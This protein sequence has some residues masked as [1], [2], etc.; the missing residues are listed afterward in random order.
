[1]NRQDNTLEGQMKK[2]M[3]FKIKLFSVVNSIISEKVFT[4]SKLQLWALV[5]DT[6]IYIYI[7]S[8]DKKKERPKL[9]LDLPH[10]TTLTAF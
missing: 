5:N 3:S 2:F 1:M 10:C 9:G 4:R 7:L 8:I 6:F